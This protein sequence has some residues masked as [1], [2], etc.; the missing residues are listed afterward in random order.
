MSFGSQEI[1]TLK[2]TKSRCE[3][4]VFTG[5]KLKF[6]KRFLAIPQT[7]GGCLYNENVDTSQAVTIHY[8]TFVIA[9]IADE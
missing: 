5:E 6:I 8:D 3:T 7:C 4:A 2:R 9:R 1:K